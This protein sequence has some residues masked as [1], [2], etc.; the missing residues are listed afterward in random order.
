MP[1]LFYNTRGTYGGF[2]NFSRRPVPV[3]GRTWPT[4]EQAY[5]AQKFHPHRPDLVEAIFNAVSPR[6]AADIG[7]NRRHPLAPS[8]DQRL[9]PS[10]IEA[11][12]PDFTFLETADL[13]RATNPLFS[14]LKDV[15]M[16]E[17]VY[18]KIAQHADLRDLLLGT[19]SEEIVEA[20]PVDA[21]W[22]WGR[23]ENGLNKLGRMFMAVRD[24]L[25]ESAA[26][27]AV[28]GKPACLP[29]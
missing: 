29:V 24:A 27:D 5:Q 23:A 22:G 4:G 2:S 25:R 14:A 20:S 13:F 1:I 10:A 7:R 15:V 16:Y 21:Y 3:Y 28:V 9:E 11:R 18:A 6:E 17:V 26:K 12:I 8:W 19:G